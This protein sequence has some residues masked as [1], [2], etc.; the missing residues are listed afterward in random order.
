MAKFFFLPLTLTFLNLTLG[1]GHHK[2]YVLK[3]YAA[4][5][6]CTKFGDC[7]SNSF[8]EKFNFVFSGMNDHICRRSNLHFMPTL[9]T[10]KSELKLNWCLKKIKVIVLLQ[11]NCLW[12]FWVFLTSSFRNIA[13][14]KWQNVNFAQNGLKS[15]NSLQTKMAISQLLIKLAL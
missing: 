4:M 12:H 6:H 13:F 8:Q 2:P 9:P 1:E 5:Y 3:C 14:Q 15:V 7:S 10:R 11:K